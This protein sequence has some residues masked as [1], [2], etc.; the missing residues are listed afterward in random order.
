M[1]GWKLVSSLLAKHVGTVGDRLAQQIAAFDPETATQVDRDNL[2][3]KLHEVAVKLAEAKQKSNKAQTAAAELKASIDG[4]VKAS[5]VLIDKFEKQ[6]IN[7]AT[8]TQF[9]DDLE[10][11]K[12]D[13]P[14]REAEADSARQLVETL[15]EILRTVETQLNEFDAK[16]RAAMADLA[17]AQADRERAQLMQQQ[18]DELNRLRASTGSASTGLGALQAAAA[19]ARV[20]AD[21]AQTVASIGQKPL[22]QQAAVEEARR[23]AAGGAAAGSESVID[24]LRRISQS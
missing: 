12:R 16:A 10:R 11:R 5:V 20:T 9:T 14:Q 18:Q 15:Q 21:A 2:Q 22:D 3:A 6:E 8:L 17:Q 19:Q 13:L 7:E 1:S 24:R 4:D 23:I